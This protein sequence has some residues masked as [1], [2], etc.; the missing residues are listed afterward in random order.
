MSRTDEAQHA[1]TPA[2]SLVRT[3][4]DLRAEGA[5]MAVQLM[6]AILN[7]DPDLDDAPVRRR[8]SGHLRLCADLPDLA[9]AMLGC[10]P[11][12]I[13]P[14]VLRRAAQLIGARGVGV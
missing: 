2:P 11:Q 14:Q 1:P 5:A 3:E 12:A 7:D 8:L 13:D 6:A 10:E 4:D 9:A